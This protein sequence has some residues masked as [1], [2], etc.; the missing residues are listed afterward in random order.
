LPQDGRFS[1]KVKNR[2][3]DVRLS[4]MPIEHGES[5]VMRLLDQTE[6][7]TELDAVGM[8]PDMLAQFRDQI[9]KPHGLVLV[10]GPTGSGK[11]TTLYGALQELNEVGKKNYHG[12]R[13]G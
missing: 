11:T 10:T 5:V 8:P 7:A 1:L 3:I 12:G 2:K 13:P 6:G 9:C 4:T